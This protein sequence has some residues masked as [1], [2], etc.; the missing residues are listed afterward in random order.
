MQDGCLTFA[1]VQA[2]I[3]G[4]LDESELEAIERHADACAACRELVT[5]S[6]AAYAVTE[7]GR[8][9]V[10]EPPKL[11]AGMVLAKRYRLVRLLGRG[12]MGEVHEAEDLELHEHIALK[13]VANVAADDDAAIARLKREVQLAR[14]VTHSNVCRVFDLGIH[15][16]EGGPRIVFLT[17]ELLRGESLAERIGRT[18]RIPPAEAAEVGAQ[19]ADALAAAHAVGVVHRDFKSGNVMLLDGVRAVITD[20]GLARAQQLPKSITTSHQGMLIGTPAY[21]A[22]EQVEGGEAT[23][24]SDIYSLG[25]VLYE[26]VTGERPFD[27][28]TPLATA[29]KRLT[30]PAPSPRTRVPGLDPLWERVIV[31]CLSRRPGG[32]FGSASQVAAILRGRAP[33]D[34]PRRG[35]WLVAFAALAILV[36]GFGIYRVRARAAPAGRPSVAVLGFQDLAPHADSAWMSTALAELLGSELAAGERLRVEPGESVAAARRDLSLGDAGSLAKPTLERLGARLGVRYVVTG[37]YFADKQRVRVD[38]VLQDTEGGDT[39]A[40]LTDT[41]S[42][43][44][45]LDLVARAGNRLRAAL[46]TGAP[47]AAQQQEV[48]ATLPHDPKAAQLYAEALELMRAFDHPTARRKLDE[49]IAIEPGFALAHAAQSDV[50]VYLGLEDLARGEADRAQSLGGALSREERLQ[51]DARWHRV[52]HR[53][54]DAV[55]SY[56]ALFTFYPDDLNYGLALARVLILAG[57]SPE[58]MQTVARLR[59]LPGAANDARIDLR[60]AQSCA[61]QGDWKCRLAADER[62]IAKAE[63]V[64][65]RLLVADAKTG[66]AQAS[67]YLGHPDRGR[68]LYRE[69][70]K[71]YDELGDHVHA[72]GATVDLAT[73][74]EMEGNLSAARKAYED[75]ATFYQSLGNTYKLADM[76]NALGQVLREQGDRAAAKKAYTESRAAF[77]SI[78]EQEGMANLDCNMADLIEDDGRVAEALPMYRRSLATFERIGMKTHAA[79]THTQIGLALARLGQLDEADAEIRTAEAALRAIG[80]QDKLEDALAARGELERVRDHLDAAQRAFEQARDIALGE[81][82]RPYAALLDTRAAEALLDAGKAADAEARARSTLATFQSLHRDEDSASALAV[83]A[84]SLA[85]QGKPDEAAQAAARAHALVEASSSWEV[86]SAV[87][88]VSALTSGSGE[89]CHAAARR[90]EQVATQAAER[91]RIAIELEARL[92]GGRIAMACGDLERGRRMAQALAGDA[93]RRGYTRIARL[94]ASAQGQN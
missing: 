29:I 15:A 46:G 83:V 55:E 61:K 8:K 63:Q 7:S 68:T 31:R 47:A 66:A 17:M 34:Q 82:E 32:R 1:Q 5:A 92:V 30:T 62:A 89:G 20:F 9:I 87:E 45:L 25:I 22:P 71:L 81:R 94:A 28:D 84:A 51:I 65:A 14:R 93:T 78:G 26:M 85:A 76:K 52:N 79:S 6:A 39:L 43:D 48:R 33:I 23:P 59:K 21:M 88:L 91:K 27:A 86:K 90:A 36:G 37:T 77:E 11:A 57:R 75:A 12:G 40:R 10:S 2:F 38:M 67:I 19:L 35:A 53:W 50:L 24:A 73:L 64:G 42:E 44:E 54:K 69:A 49:A 13:T 4:G 3:E 41:G 58:A 56:S 72:L 74:D 16:P 80:D 70:Q 60:E 18:G